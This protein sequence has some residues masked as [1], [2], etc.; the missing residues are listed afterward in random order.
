M[1]DA[2]LEQEA[3]VVVRNERAHKRDTRCKL[4][5]REYPEKSFHNEDVPFVIEPT[6]S[7]PAATAT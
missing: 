7:T 6:T 4:V 5:D 2:L 1:P 3:D